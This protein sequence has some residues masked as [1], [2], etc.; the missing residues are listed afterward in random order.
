MHHGH[1]TCRQ[2]AQ[3]SLGPGAGRAPGLHNASVCIKRLA[4]VQAAAGRFCLSPADIDFFF[5]LSFCWRLASRRSFFFVW[6]KR[7]GTAGPSPCLHLQNRGRP[8]L[9]SAA[10]PSFF[11]AARPACTLASRMRRRLGCKAICPFTEKHRQPGMAWGGRETRLPPHKLV[12][13]VQPGPHDSRQAAMG[14]FSY[15][16]HPCIRKRGAKP[17]C[18]AGNGGTRRGQGY[19]P[20]PASS[21]GG[22]AT[23][24]IE[25]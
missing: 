5:L 11:I 15:L 7:F 18:A 24:F 2:F 25:K 12:N 17:R 6:Q 3:L 14:L 9:A 20:P 22:L 16:L 10:G 19:S 1:R 23:T 8:V 13:L 4:A 21:I